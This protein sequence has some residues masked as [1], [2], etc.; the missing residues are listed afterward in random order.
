[1]ALKGMSAIKPVV[2]KANQTNHANPLGMFGF[3][4]AS[5]WFATVRLNDAWMARVEVAA[6]AL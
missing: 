6:T 2:L 4:G 3:V 5:T 1:V